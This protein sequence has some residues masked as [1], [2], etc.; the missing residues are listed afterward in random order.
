MMKELRQAVFEKV[1]EALQ[2]LGFRY[3]KRLMVLPENTTA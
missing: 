2:P 3:V 1:G